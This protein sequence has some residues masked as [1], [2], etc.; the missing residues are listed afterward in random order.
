MCKPLVSR[1]KLAS[2]NVPTL[3]ASKLLVPFT[4][5]TS[6]SENRNGGQ[7]S[8]KTSEML[9]RSFILAFTGAP[10][11]QSCCKCK[12]YQAITKLT[13]S[14]TQDFSNLSLVSEVTPRTTVSCCHCLRNDLDFAAIQQV[15]PCSAAP[16]G[17]G[18]SRRGRFSS[19]AGDEDYRSQPPTLCCRRATDE[20]NLRATKGGRGETKAA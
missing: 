16:E 5:D 15:V 19:G 11:L 8:S 4:K 20:K 3:F 1:E 17:R 18:G 13:P 7:G 12:S 10:L 9:T 14:T 2:P 6:I